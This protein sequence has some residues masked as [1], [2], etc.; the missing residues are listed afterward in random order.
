MTAWTGSLARTPEIIQAS[1]CTRRI[2]G[3]N[4][5]RPIPDFGDNVLQIR[6]FYALPRKC[7]PTRAL[8]FRDQREWAEEYHEF[9]RWRAWEYAPRI[10]CASVAVSRI[11][12]RS[13]NRDTSVPSLTGK[14]F[15]SSF[16][17]PR[18]SCFLSL[19]KSRGTTS[20]RCNRPSSGI[21][22]KIAVG[23]PSNCTSGWLMEQGGQ[24]RSRSLSLFPSLSLSRKFPKLTGTWEIF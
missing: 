19:F 2:T 11:A 12:Y 8:Y 24:M 9:S 22:C 6:A 5:R 23:R 4:P 13:L 16:L 3:I 20:L 1:A 10:R 21:S 18:F 14:S 15:I 7:F 17:F